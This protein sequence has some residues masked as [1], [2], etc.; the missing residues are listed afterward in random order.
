MPQTK[1]Q[2]QYIVHDAALEVLGK[3]AKSGMDTVVE[4]VEQQLDHPLRLSA[5]FPTPDAVLNIGA[6]QIQLSDGTGRS[7]P[8]NDGSI[9][10]FPATTINFQTQAISGGTVLITWP[11][12]TVG[13]FRRL[14]FTLLPT[15]EVQANF[16][17]EAAS[18][19]AL[20]NA[21][22]LF[23]NG[24]IPIG[25]IDLECTNAA[26]AFKTAGSV[27]DIIENSVG[28][29]AR[30]CRMASIAASAAGDG[31]LVKDENVSVAPAAT[32]LNFEGAGVT[33]EETTPGTARIFVPGVS[34]VL[35]SF[36]NADVV[37]DENGDLVESG[38]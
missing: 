27:T 22:T 9:P 36:L 17:A 5:S 12:S 6:Q 33:A 38:E 20:A 32:V 19:G 28:G 25:W 18:V 26:P 30:I 8:P 13:L 24:G 37:I 15:G 11:G 16:S 29:T 1:D 35:T 34:R 7:I 21:G 2:S 4:A 23:V 31:V 10:S 14:A 3:A